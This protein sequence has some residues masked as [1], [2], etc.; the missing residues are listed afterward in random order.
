M[1][2]LKE[3]CERLAAFTHSVLIL[4]LRLPE[5]VVGA[6]ELVG[7]CLFAGAANGLVV[8]LAVYFVTGKP[9]TAV[10]VGAVW[11]GGVSSYLIFVNVTARRPEGE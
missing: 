7:N 4:L 1:N 3:M 6:V 9:F 8:G 2:D 10:L 11:A 5:K